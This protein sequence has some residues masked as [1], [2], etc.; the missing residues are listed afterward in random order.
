V[1]M[2]PPLWEESGNN[3]L[4]KQI[5]LALLSAL[6]LSMKE[7]GAELHSMI[8]PIIRDTVSPGSQLGFILIED[9]LDLWATVVK[10]TPTPNSPSDINP[11]LI[12]LVDLLLPML[13]MET[14]YIERV[15]EILESYMLLIPAVIFSR[16]KFARILT[17]FAP[18]LGTMHA[19][20]SGYLTSAIEHAVNISIAMNGPAAAQEILYQ[21]VETRFFDALVEGMKEAWIAHQ[22]TGPKAKMTKIQG[23][24]ETD[25]LS[26]LSRIVWVAPEMFVEALGKSPVSAIPQVELAWKT[27]LHIPKLP[28]PNQLQGV[29]AAM[30]WFTD[31]WLDHTDDVGDLARQKLMV[32]ALT[33]LL[34]LSKPYML[35]NMQTLMNLWTKVILELTDGEVQEEN[36]RKLDGLVYT[37]EQH[38]WMP[39]SGPS[40]A[41]EVRR[42]LVFKLDPVHSVDLQVL[43]KECLGRFIERCGGEEGFRNEVL[44]NVDKEVIDAFV[45]LGIM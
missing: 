21:M 8:L 45:G 17:A 27:S 11:E 36:G 28:D 1:E 32:M 9:T 25:Y 10:Q 22:T 20:Q 35:T 34:D 16:E 26:L 6:F 40:S 39:D 37:E 30:R 23:I 15:I 5:I 43:V 38:N 4:M 3:H 33:R 31:E 42:K 7:E 44:V 24:I 19:T 13:D 18:K 2:L 29:D 12:S 14:E 41:D